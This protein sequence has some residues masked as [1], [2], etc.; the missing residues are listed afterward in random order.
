M[1]LQAIWSLPSF[2]SCHLHKS[3]CVQLRHILWALTFLDLQCFHQ[4]WLSSAFSHPLGS[5]VGPSE[6]PPD[7]VNFCCNPMS[8]YIYLNCTVFSV[9][10]TLNNENS[11]KNNDLQ[12]KVC[13]PLTL[14][15]QASPRPATIP[16][17]VTHWNIHAH[18][19]LGFT[20]LKA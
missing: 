9:S 3:N 14:E 20:Q 2:I 5:F 17:I 19:A 12:C 11:K 8:I 15:L 10:L 18:I 7:R 16:M 1:Y 4:E 13:L 6:T